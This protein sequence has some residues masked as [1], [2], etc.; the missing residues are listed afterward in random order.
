MV[1]MG[2]AV[3]VD[4]LR[5]HHLIHPKSAKDWLMPTTLYT[6]TVLTAKARSQTMPIHWVLAVVQLTNCCCRKYILISK[7]CM[8]IQLGDSAQ[9]QLP[10][11]YLIVC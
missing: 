9:L 2:V 7:C 8:L 5:A 4:V 3:L 10:K 1:V 6:G 11:V